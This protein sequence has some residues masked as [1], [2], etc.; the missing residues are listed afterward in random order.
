M[1]SVGNSL[2]EAR[3]RKKISLKKAAKDLHIKK[4]ILEDLESG[5]F[6][7]LPEPTYVKGIL[8]SYSPYLGLNTD[9]MLALYRRGF[10]EAKKP[11]K[12]TAFAKE[13]R[14]MITPN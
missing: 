2:K 10:D 5:F 7:K 6:L 13:K 14:L 3:N 9:H 11:R 12:K 1:N 4:E 8:R